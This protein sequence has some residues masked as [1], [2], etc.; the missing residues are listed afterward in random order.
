[1][2]NRVDTL[3]FHLISKACSRT[4]SS[5]FS[6]PSNSVKDIYKDTHI[7]FQKK[8]P[9]GNL[10]V[11]L[12]IIP[13]LLTSI[14]EPYA[15]RLTKRART[16]KPVDT[17][18]FFV[19]ISLHYLSHVLVKYFGVMLGSHVYSLAG[20]HTVLNMYCNVQVPLWKVSVQQRL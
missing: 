11:A 19:S 20:V 8:L 12:Q 14:R 13:Q 18:D 2:V 17:A 4:H 7:G 16:H 9:Q 3:D 5:I 15:R 10:S 1:M 6:K